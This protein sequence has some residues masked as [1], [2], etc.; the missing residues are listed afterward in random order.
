MNVR[1][2]AQ[3]KLHNPKHYDGL[4]ESEGIS[5]GVVCHIQGLCRQHMC[6]HLSNDMSRYRRPDTECNNQD[7]QRTQEANRKCS[8]P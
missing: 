1:Q 4:L 2:L 7:C 6:Q 5:V 3:Y 8:C